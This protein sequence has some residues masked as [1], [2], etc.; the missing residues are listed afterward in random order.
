MNYLAPLLG[1][2]FTGSLMV[3]GQIPLESIPFQKLTSKSDE[4]TQGESLF[5]LLAPED[6]GVDFQIQL[7]DMVRF[8]HELL[9]L[10]LMG[11]LAVG[12]FDADGWTDF[13]VPS[14]QGGGRL[15]R[16]EGGLRFSDVTEISGLAN[17]SSWETGAGFV[18]ID[19][20]GD[21]DL[22]IC[23]YQSP[24]RVFL[25]KGKD[26]DDAGA[27]FEEKA[28]LLGLDF[29]GASMQMSFADIDLDGDLDAYLATT[30]APPPAGVE[31]RVEFE[32]SRPVIPKELR[33][34]WE[35]LYLPGEKAHR[36]EAGQYDRL[37][38]ND[39]GSFVDVTE[40]SGI[41]GAYFT[42]SSIWFDCNQD[43][44]PDLYVA[45]DYLGPD[46]L[47]IN[48]KDGTFKDLIKEWAP[49][50][51][52]SSMGLSQGDLNNDGLF[53]LRIESNGVVF[54]LC[55]ST[56]IQPKCGSAEYG[57]GSISRCRIPDRDGS[58]GLDLGPVGG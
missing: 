9:H 42:L 8:S 21:L 19:N 3:L 38:R 5:R 33:E 31:F 16:N 47:Y 4:G 54:R 29:S 49:H 6:S 30:A 17:S 45:N 10:S 13:Y 14:P 50:I 32:G 20:D 28:Q 43:G 34:Y 48:Q 26:T 15:F 41:T 35:L 46:R 39:N 1:T 25:N 44:W 58:Y 57:N 56:P 52:W 36:T 37:Y 12:D 11:G 2:F 27:R 55:R 40:T 24:N 7:P 51:P 23:A 18:D 22:V 53:D